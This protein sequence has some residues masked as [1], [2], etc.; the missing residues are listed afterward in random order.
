MRFTVWLIAAGTATILSGCASPPE[1]PPSPDP[2][3]G[4]RPALFEEI[5]IL[6]PEKAVLGYPRDM[7]S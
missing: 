3:A 4:K 7:K 1:P 5:E 6:N 2:N